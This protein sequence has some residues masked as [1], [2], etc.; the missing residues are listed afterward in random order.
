MGSQ[1]GRSA[2]AEAI[3]VADLGLRFVLTTLIGAAGGFWLDRRFGWAEKFPVATIAGFFL[4]LA[5][6]MVLLVR[7]LVRRREEERRG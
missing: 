5:A 7:G 1:R 6:A 2:L 4:G 3:R